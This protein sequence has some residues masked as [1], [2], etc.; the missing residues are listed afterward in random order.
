MSGGVVETDKLDLATRW[1]YSRAKNI[2]RQLN[3][4]YSNKERYEP[5][6]HLEGGP[7]DETHVI[8]IWKGAGELPDSYLK[9][10]DP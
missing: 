1:S 10:T 7:D 9:R 6:K 4:V 5:L 3:R 8:G 2:C